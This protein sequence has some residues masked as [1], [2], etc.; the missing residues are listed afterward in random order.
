NG[1]GGAEVG[2][3][4]CEFAVL[5]LELLHTTQ[6]AGAKP[7]IQLLPAIERLLGN[8]HP[9]DDLGHRRS[10][11]RLLQGKGNL[12]LGK[13]ALLHGFAP[14]LRVS[15]N[16]KTRIQ[17]GGEKREDV[18]SYLRDRCGGNSSGRLAGPGRP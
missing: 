15:Q 5:V 14:P 13:P 10:R 3:K 18:N 16:R 1:V 4:L 9:P 12:L 8:P 2:D 11:L 7:A 17:T 6:L